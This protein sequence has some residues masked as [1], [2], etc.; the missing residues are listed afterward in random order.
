MTRADYVAVLLADYRGLPGRAGPTH[1]GDRRLAAELHRRHVPLAIAR[2]ALLLG[3]ARR[4]CHP[5]GTPPLPPIRSLAYFLP[6]IAELTAATPDPAYLDHLA[7]LTNGEQTW[8]P[9]RNSPD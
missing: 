8:R 4:A 5:P 2:T 9:P 3:A 7:R 6:I 1:P